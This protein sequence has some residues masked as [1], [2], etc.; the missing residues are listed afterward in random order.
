MDLE[1]K[2]KKVLITG[3]SRGIGAAIARQFLIEGA[4]VVITSRGSKQ[5]F[6]TESSLKKEFGDLRVRAE[7]CDCTNIDSL[8]ELKSNIGKYYNDLDMV[9]SNVGDGE[10]VSDPLPD[11]NQWKKIW[12]INFESALHTARTFLPL[13]W[14]HLE[15]LLIIQQL[16]QR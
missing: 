7:I 16:R 15:L 6:N 4:D 11:F 1:I 12:D 14:R 2:G 3:S 8:L 5:L 9:I 10:S 13:L